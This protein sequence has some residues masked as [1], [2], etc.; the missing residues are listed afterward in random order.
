MGTRATAAAAKADGAGWNGRSDGPRRTA[1]RGRGTGV[2]VSDD[3]SG[4]RRLFDSF[5]KSSPR[6]PCRSASP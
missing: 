4:V 5:T 2:A 1:I 3:Y 6:T